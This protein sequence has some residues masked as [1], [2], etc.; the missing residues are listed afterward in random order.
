MLREGGDVSAFT[1]DFRAAFFAN[2]ATTATSAHAIA[3]H[4]NVAERGVL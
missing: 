2:L 1:S 4:I 3:S